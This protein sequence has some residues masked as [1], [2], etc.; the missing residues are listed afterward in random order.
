MMQEIYGNEA[1]LRLIRSMAEHSCIPHACLI[2]G[3]KGLGKKTIAQYL[4]MAA[5]CEGE[6]KPCGVCKSCRRV[7]NGSHLDIL[8]VEHSGKRGGFSVETIRFVCRDS[9]AAPNNGYRKIYLFE[10]CDNM[11]VVSQNTLLKL[12]EEP[13]PHVLLIFTAEHKG[14]FLETMLSRMMHF[15]AGPCSAELC[16]QAL[17]QKGCTPEEAQFASSVAGGNIGKALDWLRSEQMQEMT[18]HIA[19]ITRAM[20]GHNSYEIL[21]IL[22]LYEK[23]RNTALEF[24]RLLDVQMRD[25]AALKFLPG[26]SIGCDTASA[27]ALSGNL[28]VRRALQLHEAIQEAYAALQAN[29]SV[30]LVLAALGGAL[31]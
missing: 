13:P 25:A 4:A 3:E 15:A 16:R 8:R 24:L 20:A 5:L 11:S 18:K 23:D 10:D 1:T 7:Q 14:V 30:R 29:V 19:A 9:I 27:A 28:S 31:G 26:D 21:R 12:T 6:Q 22:Y 17:V 2:H